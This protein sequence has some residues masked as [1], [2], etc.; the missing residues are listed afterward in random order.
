MASYGL[1]V[2]ETLVLDPQNEPFPSQITRSVG[3][4]Q[5]QEIQALN[6]PPFVDVRTDGMD[7]ESPALAGLQAVTLNW[8]SP[9]EIDEAKNEGREVHTLL[10][11]T[12][13]SWL[14]ADPNIQPDPQ[15]YPDFG[16]PIEGQPQ[17]YPLAVS[18][19]GVFES[20]YKGKASPLAE[21]ANAETPPVDPATG[22]PI[23]IQDVGTI[24]T[25]PETARLVVIGSAEFL[26]D[27]VFQLSSNLS[28][29]RYFNSLQ[30]MQNLVDWSV[31]DLDLLTI[32]SRSSAARVLEPMSDEQQTGWEIANYVA[33]LLAVLAVGWIWQMRRQNEEPMTLIP[34][35]GF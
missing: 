5:V 7:Q 29:D 35:G 25:S 18:A 16:F 8:V 1:S 28:F 32:R 11:S 3:G 23:E 33:A 30:F 21:A 31:E 17:A 26:N 2:Q 22:A 14:R 10:N 19:Q 15:T 24:E 34:P 6:Y 4:L 13:G 12:A 20:F 27:I 9:I